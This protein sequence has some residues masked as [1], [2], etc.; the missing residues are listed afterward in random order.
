MKGTNTV[1]KDKS[2]RKINGLGK[3]SRILLTI[4]FVVITVSI[5]MCIVL[6]IYFLTLPD[7]A[8]SVNADLGG[9]ITVSSEVPENMIKVEEDDIDIGKGKN[10]LVYNVTETRAEDGSRIYD[11]S[12]GLDKAAGMGF[13]F[14]CMG[15]MFLAAVSM[16]FIAVIV[17]FGKRLAKALEKCSSPFEENVIKKMKAFGISMIPWAGFK[18]IIG[19]IGGITT[20]IFVLVV[21]LFIAVFN[22]GAKLQKESDETL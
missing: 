10:H 3:A 13:K 7:D 8:V 1:L 6:G 18:L 16:T 21:L 22:Y 4:A 9:R 2:I 15:L 20:A 19:T 12:L 14:L 11:I 5:V 17:I